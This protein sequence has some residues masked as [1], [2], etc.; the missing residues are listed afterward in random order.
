MSQAIPHPGHNLA[1]LAAYACLLGM[2]LWV[3]FCSA[4]VA[5]SDPGNWLAGF[6]GLLL[7]GIGLCALGAIGTAFGLVARRTGAG[8]VAL[9]L[10]AL[11]FLASGIALLYFLG[12]ML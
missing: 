3:A 7:A 6:A 12:P 8:V 11:V 9:I 1:A 2:V 4:F 5:R 10:N